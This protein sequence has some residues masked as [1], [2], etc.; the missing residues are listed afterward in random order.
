MAKKTDY[1]D[2]QRQRVGNVPNWGRVP[3]ILT[4]GT[5]EAFG[6]FEK[7][8]FNYILADAAEPSVPGWLCANT[9]TVL[10]MADLSG[11]AVLLTT[12]VTIEDTGQMQ[13]GDGVGG[14]FWPAATKEIFYETRLKHTIAGTNV[15]KLAFGLIDPCGVTEICVDGNTRAPITAVDHLCF[16][17]D[18]DTGNAWQFEG[19]KGG[20]TDLNALTQTPESLVFHTYGF[21]VY[22]TTTALPGFCDVYYD[23]AI[24]AAGQVLHTSIPVTGLT[25]FLCIKTGGA[26]IEAVYVDYTMCVELR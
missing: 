19:R 17:T 18:I 7:F 25:P 24:I 14:A 12:G 4:P 22:G 2:A 16:L 26:F 11:G 20:V 13:L 5:M 6:I 23:R 10:S 15:L 21:H 9:A 3:A 1:I 8:G